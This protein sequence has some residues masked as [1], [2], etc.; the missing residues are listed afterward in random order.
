MTE[1][2]SGHI[3]CID[4]LGYLQTVVFHFVPDHIQTVAPCDHE[5]DKQKYD[6]RKSA[7]QGDIAVHKK[8][9]IRNH[10]HSL[11]ILNHLH[12]QASHEHK[13]TE[14]QHKIGKQYDNQGH[15]VYLN[16][17]HPDNIKQDTAK[18][19]K[20]QY[21]IDYGNGRAENAP[22]PFNAG[23]RHITRIQEGV[24]ADIYRRAAYQIFQQKEKPDNRIKFSVFLPFLLLH[25]RSGKY[26]IADRKKDTAQIQAIDNRLLGNLQGIQPGG[27]TPGHQEILEEDTQVKGRLAKI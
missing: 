17:W 21:K 11:G 15:S 18:A 23:Y 27:H 6:I 13:V 3:D 25:K 24:G 19:H 22:K 20:K 5:Q 2:P 12:G 7:V 8:D 26:Q 9:F 1:Y 4:V 10:I 16:V 14:Y